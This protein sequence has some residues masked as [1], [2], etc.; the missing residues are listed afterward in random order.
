MT[1]D[2]RRGFVFGML[3]GV[4]LAL[5][6][7][8]IAYAIFGPSGPTAIDQARTQVE[9]NYYHAVNGRFL[10]NSSIAGMVNQLRHRYHDRFS[11]YLDPRSLEQFNSDTS[12]QFEGVGLTVSGVKRGLRVA[13]VIP[14]TPAERAGVKRGDL[15]TG[16]NGQSLE[17]KPTNASV[18]IIRGVPGTSVKLRVVPAGAQKPRTISVKRADVQVPAVHGDMKSADGQKV[19]DV[20]F[21]TFSAGAH[22]ELRDAV[23]RLYSRGAKGLLLD[24][25]GNGGGLLEEAVLGASVFLHKGQRVVSTDSRTQG[26]RVYRATG[27]QLERKPIV[28][29]VD[30]DTASAAEILTAALSEQGLATVVGT[31]TYGKGTF[32]QAIDLPNGGALDLT[33]GRFFTANGSSTLNKGIK[34]D[35]HAA[36]NPATTKVDEGQRKALAVLGRELRSG[37]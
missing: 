1:A 35:I 37:R 33:I 16:A 36:D 20:K 29:L 13:S 31:R 2:R 25:R 6:A 7:G 5:A 23:N 22:G 26:H 9:D 8:G 27:D 32:Q 4:A 19:A 14:G 21:T 17:G 10:D 30:H 11:R 3:A 15:I 34:P 12:G 24:L 28:V 18:A